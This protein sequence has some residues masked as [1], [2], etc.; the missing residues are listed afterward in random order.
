MDKISSRQVI[1]TFGLIFWL[2]A[3]T[4]TNAPAADQPPATPTLPAEPLWLEPSAQLEHGFAVGTLAFAPDDSQLAAGDGHGAIR[5]CGTTAWQLDLEVDHDD[6]IRAL[7]FSP[8]GQQL[9]SGSFDRTARLW[10]TGSGEQLAEIAHGYW[11]YGLAFS[12]DGRWLA[13]GGLGG[14]LYVLEIA[15]GQQEQL[16]SEPELG[17]HY[18]AFSPDGHW[19]AAV[20]SGSWGPGRVQVWDTQSHAPTVLAEFDGVAYSNLDFSP[21]G[22]YLAAGLGSGG[23]LTVWDTSDW[24]VEAELTAS[25]SDIP[26]GAPNIVAVSPNGQRLAAVISNCPGERGLISIWDTSDWVQATRVEAEDVIFAAAFSPDSLSLAVGLGQGIEHSPLNEAQLWDVAS[27]TLVARMPHNQQVVA[28]AF[29]H[30]GQWLASGSADRTV[31]VWDLVTMPTAAIPPEQALP[32]SMKGYELYSWQV[33]ESWYFSLLVGTNR[34]K[35]YDEVTSPTVR[36]EG[37]ARLFDE[38]D[39]LLS[40][41]QVFWLADRVPGTPLP[42]DDIIE[43]ITTHCER[44]GI[45][46][47]I[48]R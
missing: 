29:S 20:L 7:A 41:E 4:T 45:Q 21:D 10:D 43:A 36:V 35:T 48:V 30:D 27:G 44:R 9:A 6:S 31:R 3:C 18:L 11:V 15:A 22:R 2:G 37:V 39:Q 25:C 34:I 26:V 46:L 5:V 24:Q 16:W 47:E 32:R 40:G 8:D 14:A 1:L 17:V 33:E 42:P 23:P 13:S 19:L 12:P 28:L 38:M